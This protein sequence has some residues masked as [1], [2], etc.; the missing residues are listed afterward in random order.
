MVL[1]GKANSRAGME[2]ST[3]IIAK[4]MQIEGVT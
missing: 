2:V 1:M 3:I 4:T